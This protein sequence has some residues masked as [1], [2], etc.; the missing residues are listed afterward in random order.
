[1]QE[2]QRLY[3]AVDRAN[4]FV[5]IPGT[6]AGIPAIEWML[7]AGIPINITLLFAIQDYESVAQA[8]MRALER[9][10]ANGLPVHTVASVASFFLSRIDVLVDQ[11][12]EHRIRPG[13]TNG[14]EPGPEQLLGKVA[15]ANAK[16]AYQ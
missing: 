2:A 6:P 14:H 13:H 3:N 16:L 10:L 4:V 7:Y 11:L 9:R 15:V 5:K 1:M 8:Y 12:L